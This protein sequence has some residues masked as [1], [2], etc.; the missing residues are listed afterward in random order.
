MEQRHRYV[1]GVILET[2][3]HCLASWRGL[4]RGY[5]AWVSVGNRGDCGRDGRDCVRG[6]RG[7][8]GGSMVSW[9]SGGL[10]AWEPAIAFS[11]RKA[12]QAG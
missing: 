8:D 7:C 6:G 9:T 12:W 4:R 5:H 1:A 10:V 11:G 2:N 3:S